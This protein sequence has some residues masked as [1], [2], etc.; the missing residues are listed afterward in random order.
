MTIDPRIAAQ[1]RGETPLDDTGPADQPMTEE[2]RTLALDVA[3]ALALEHGIDLAPLI[4]R[5]RAEEEAY[6][7]RMEQELGDDA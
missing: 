5:Q 7:L 1:I 6:R 3:G 4:A 2:E